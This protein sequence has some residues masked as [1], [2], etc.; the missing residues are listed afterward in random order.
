M[1]IS[2]SADYSATR[3]PRSG[4]TQ[5]GKPNNAEI[6]KKDRSSVGSITSKNDSDPAVA[7]N[8]LGPIQATVT[9]QS[10]RRNS[11]AGRGS[12]TA[13]DILGFTPLA[14]LGKIQSESLLKSAEIPSEKHLI[15]GVPS[16]QRSRRGS[17]DKRPNF[18]SQLKD[19]LDKH[20]MLITKLEAVTGSELDDVEPAEN[21]PTINVSL[22][23]P[24][25]RVELVPKRTEGQR[26]MKQ[27]MARKWK[28]L[29]ASFTLMFRLCQLA[30]KVGKDLFEKMV[31]N[32]SSKNARIPYRDKKLSEQI[33]QFASKRARDGRD[34]DGMVHLLTNKLKSFRLYSREQR[35]AICRIMH[36]SSY[37]EVHA[38]I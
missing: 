3:S 8:S 21:S 18:M 23:M 22:A 13:K 37:P 4:S 29:H 26:P 7:E 6:F 11:R 25:E 38:L 14:P 10:S 15:A 17:V 35:E 36:F 16:G 24:I 19:V 1:S 28:M 9:Y 2:T 20:D 32:A 31:G 12:V 27:L 33:M 5:S 30:R 34:I